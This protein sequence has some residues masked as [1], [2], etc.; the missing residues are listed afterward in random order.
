MTWAAVDITWFAVGFTNIGIFPDIANQL[1]RWTVMLL[2]LRGIVTVFVVAALMG[3]LF[4]EQRQVTLE[5]AVLASEMHAA[6]EIQRMLAPATIATAPGLNIEVAFHPMREVGGDFYLCRV[7]PDGRQRILVGDV[8]GKGAAAAMAAAVLLGAAAARDSDSPSNLLA[9][10]NRV[11]RENHLTGFA[12]CLC[13]DLAVTGEVLVANAG[14]LPPYSRGEELKIASGL[15]LG[16]A[17]DASYA[18]TALTLEADDRLTFL[19]D[20]VVEARNGAG[21]LFGF[22][23]AARISTEPAEEV[24]RAAQTF[25]QEDDITVLTLKFAPAAVLHA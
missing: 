14:H 16:V 1:A 11:F 7:L 12:T 25:G 4:R 15:P 3:L 6:S 5:R 19:S 20:G 21:E 18:E 24:A 17:A 22:D 9:S 10:L 2:E 8:S 23:R 13:A